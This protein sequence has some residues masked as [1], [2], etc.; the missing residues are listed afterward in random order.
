MTLRKLQTVMPSMK[1]LIDKEMRG[2]VVYKFTCPCYQA[3]YVGFTYRHLK[4]RE[5]PVA[6]HA[7]NCNESISGESFDILASS[8]CGEDFLMTLEA[9][10]IRELAP[11]INTKDE[12][13]MRELTINVSVTL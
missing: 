4:T 6:K 10:W 12:W 3:C 5:E 9:L 11:E 7:N 8:S 13:K 2:G 1:P